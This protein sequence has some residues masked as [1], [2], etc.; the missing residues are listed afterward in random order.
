MA[1]KRY[2]SQKQEKCKNDKS[3]VKI[4][5]AVRGLLARKKIT[6]L[7]N[8]IDISFVIQLQAV[9]RGFLIRRNNKI[10]KQHLLD[11]LQSIITMQSAIKGFLARKKYNAQMSFLKL[12]E[13]EIIKIQSMYRGY[14]VRKAFNA[15]TRKK[16]TPLACLQMFCHLLEEDENDVEEDYELQELRSRIIKKIKDN[17]E[18]DISLNELDI[19]IALLVKN[20]ITLEEVIRHTKKEKEKKTTKFNKENIEKMKLFGNL[21]YLLQT[22]PHYVS[23]LLFLAGPNKIK[24][25]TETVVF[26]L[27]GYG[28]NAREEYLILKLIESTMNEEIDTTEDVH[29]VMK[30]NLIF[31][32]LI[33][34]FNRGAKERE[35]LR[36]L[37]GPLVTQILNEKEC[38]LE[39]DPL[40]V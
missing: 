27:F 9:I 35:Y 12:H 25:L 15:I 13:R 7:K 14:L 40:M 31:I 11:N 10:A 36:N 32:K 8:G 22:Q 3:A 24:S 1:K 28:Q 17:N 2:L 19:K 37:L 30:E 4:Q 33:V 39:T 34:Q 29:G 6:Q 5:A 38:D 18:C 21:Y 16:E 26:G 23:K 20:S